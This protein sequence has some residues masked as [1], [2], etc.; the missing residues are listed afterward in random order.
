MV[1]GGGQRGRQRGRGRCN[2]AV[3]HNT[4]TRPHR[5]GPGRAGPGLSPTRAN[6]RSGPVSGSGP[7][8][9]PCPVCPDRR[10]G[11]MTARTRLALGRGLGAPGLD[12]PRPT[13]TIQTNDS[14]KWP[15]RDQYVVRT[16]LA[17]DHDLRAPGLDRP[18]P[19][20]TTRT[21]DP[22]KWP[23]RALRLAMVLGLQ[24][25]TVLSL[26]HVAITAPSADHAT[27]RT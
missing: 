16:I 1:C 22:D 18:R 15:G 12:R 7:V 21:N 27:P 19:T 3:G 26:L 17:H 5:A 25:L 2:S 4:W 11:Q 10:P 8:D 14:E 6:P 20:R 23:G 13:R 9:A 24:V